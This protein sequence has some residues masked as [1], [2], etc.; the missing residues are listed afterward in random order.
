MSTPERLDFIPGAS[1]AG[2]FLVDGSVP[3]DNYTEAAV[4]AL[5]GR[6]AWAYFYPRGPGSILCALARSR[7]GDTILV[8]NN[9]DEADAWYRARLAAKGL[10]LT[11]RRRRR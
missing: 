3:P 4:R 7:T 11:Q 8:A 2:R 1:L 9:L 6:I 10:P 5:P